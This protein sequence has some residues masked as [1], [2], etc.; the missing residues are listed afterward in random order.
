MGTVTPGD[1]KGETVFMKSGRNIKTASLHLRKKNKENR[2]H[3]FLRKGRKPQ[4]GQSTALPGPPLNP[5][6]ILCRR[7]IANPFRQPASSTV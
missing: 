1:P 4:L 3:S 6:V 2:I 5:K 7:H